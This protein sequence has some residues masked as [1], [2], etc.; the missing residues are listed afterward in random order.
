M[1]SAEVAIANTETVQKITLDKGLV[2]PL[3]SQYNQLHIKKV[4]KSYFKVKSY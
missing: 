1:D 3:D 4:G 2:K